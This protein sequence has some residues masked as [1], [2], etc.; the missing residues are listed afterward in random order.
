MRRD[1]GLPA[2]VLIAGTELRLLRRSASAV[3]MAAVLPTGI[4]LLVVWAEGD[5]GRAGWG[6]AAGLILVM[7]VALTA[8]AA[9][10]TV[11][12][13]RRQQFVLK[14]LRTSGASDAAIIAGVVVPPAVL[15][16]LQTVLLFSI[17]GVLGGPPP[18]RALPLLLAV[19]MG[20]A[21]ACVLAV[22]TAAF[23]STPESAQL[24]TGPIGLAFCGGGLWV[25]STP[26]GEVTGAMLALP[27][28]SI[29]HLTRIGWGEPDMTGQGGAV[30]ALVL[31]AV[32]VT[33]LAVRAFTWDPR[34]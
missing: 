6:A 30:V 10:T 26:P 7:L 19:G 16:V 1:G 15:T 9:G 21:A 25:V 4:G 29:A 33:P 8:Y 34:R 17:V 24:T 28:G 31:I 20:A 14:R 3:T 5:T 2:W 11:L 12:A 22:L 18:V 32:V 27:G 13:A 23:T